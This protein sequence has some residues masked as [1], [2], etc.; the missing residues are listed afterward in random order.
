[1]RY[2]NLQIG[3][4]LAIVVVVLNL[5]LIGLL[6]LLFFQQFQ[7]ALNER[8][9]LQLSSILQLKKVQIERL[10]SETQAELNQTGTVPK[11][12]AVLFDT[13][14]VR[15]GPP[16][17][18][19]IP[20][21]TAPVHLPPLRRNAG[22]I[23]D[24]TPAHP[25]GRMTFAFQLPVD[26][27]QERWVGLTLDAVQEILFE[28]TGMGETGESY[29]VGQDTTL[30]SQSRFFPQTNPTHLRVA[31]EGAMAALAG[32]AGH[33]Q[34]HDY[35]DVPVF[36][37]Y[38]PLEIN[39]LH[40]AILSEID[41]REALEPLH[42]LRT[43]LWLLAGAVLFLTVVVT[44]LL[45]R[46]VTQPIVLME[47]VLN[48]MSK[49]D[50]SP[51][52]PPAASTDELGR[53]HAAL[54]RLVGA[55]KQTIA[56]ADQIG[57]GDFEA[58]Y[59]LA[60]QEDALGQA[61]LRMRDQLKAYQ[62][63][64]QAFRRENQRSL[65]R[66]VETERARLAK[67]LHDGLG[68][69]LTSL[70]MRIQALPLT[71]PEKEVLKTQLDETIQE[72][73]RMSYNLM[74]SVLR[75]F[76]VG[77]AVQNLVTQMQGITSTQLRYVNSVEEGVVIP[78]EVGTALYRI[79]QEALHNGIR[80][81]QAAEIRLSITTFEDRISFYYRDNGVGF[82]TRREYSGLGLRNM[83]ER[84]LLLDGMFVLESDASGTLLEIELPL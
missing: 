16:L 11:A 48:T 7:L 50:L 74:P 36:S 28:R 38:E 13:L 33:V 59:P 81:A 10:L 78:A 60:S 17:T 26:G 55:L 45:S 82:D 1:M 73:R 64:E 34:T 39:G 46:V 3:T 21:L 40:W 56:Y 63:K 37:A 84:V 47:K 15:Q 70:K 8:V 62:E 25:T 29:L 5:S 14:V 4:K 76:G 49:G 80:H 22:T 77:E 18:L 35:R 6:S 41:E 27:Q 52:V 57:A 83:R 19:H 51:E 65:L 43:R 72:V 42:R 79:A 69:L 44:S 71:S 23:H 9:L 61:L 58:D 67:E 24:L 75:D 54:A 68:P 53:M 32:N 2:R 20:S 12:A 30:R 66:G 31:T